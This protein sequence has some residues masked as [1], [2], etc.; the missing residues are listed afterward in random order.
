MS[1]GKLRSTSEALEIMQGAL[2]A[3]PLLRAGGAWCEAPCRYV[4]GLVC[5]LKRGVAFEASRMDGS[6]EFE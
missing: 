1:E 3:R 4:C 2:G 6:A 5:G